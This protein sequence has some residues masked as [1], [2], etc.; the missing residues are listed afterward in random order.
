MIKRNINKDDFIPGLVIF[1]LGIIFILFVIPNQIPKNSGPIA[2]SPRLFCQI[3]TLLIIILSL[4]LIMKSLSPKKHGIYLSETKLDISEKIRVIISILCAIGY[5]ICLPI[6]GYFVSTIIFL[7][8]FLLFFGAKKWLPII[9]T[10]MIITIFLY[11]VFVK[12]LQVVLPSGIL[13]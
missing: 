1:F 8:F 9:S 10:I 11:L 12:A 2:L 7:L 13:F 6:F 4:L 3:A 5:V